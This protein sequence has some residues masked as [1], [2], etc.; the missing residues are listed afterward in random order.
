[1]SAKIVKADG[2]AI[3]TT[4]IVAGSEDFF[5]ALFESV[6]VS[7]N[8]VIVSKLAPFYPFKAHI[9]NLLTHGKDYK[10]TILTSELYYP[11]SKPD[12]FTVAANEGFKTRMKFSERSLTF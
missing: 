7:I 5:S 4:D 12:T 3:S 11:D 8:G 2:S 9:L 6:V 10:D 1:V